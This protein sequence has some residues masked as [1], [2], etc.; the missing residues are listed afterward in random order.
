M[1][2][3]QAI[4]NGRHMDKLAE[5]FTKPRGHWSLQHTSAEARAKG[6]DQSPTLEPS[7]PCRHSTP[8]RFPLCGSN[9]VLYDS[10]SRVFLF[11]RACFNSRHGYHLLLLLTFND[12]LPPECLAAISAW[13]VWQ[14]QSLAR[15]QARALQE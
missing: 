9:P 13:Y 11:S 2:G 14:R 12:V 15:T 8:A 5:A 1:P 4:Q 3:P 10:I 6:L 7:R